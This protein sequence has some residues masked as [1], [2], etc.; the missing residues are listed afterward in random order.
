[1]KKVWLLIT[2]LIVIVMIFVMYQQHQLINDYRS[3]LYSE[4]E[5]LNV[6]I[7]R[8]LAFHQEGENLVEKERTEKLERLDES[9]A[10]FFNHTGTGLQLEPEI[11]EKYYIIYNDTKLA[12]SHLIE[13]YVAAST[14][15][16]REQAYQNLQEQYN[17]YNE[18]LEVS[19]DEFIEPI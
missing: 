17:Q 2:S 13:S 14:I 18:F 10:D 3:L 7:E 1:M 9:F 15:E 5:K 11:S 19:E 16:E 6:P 12:Y 4:M 8:I